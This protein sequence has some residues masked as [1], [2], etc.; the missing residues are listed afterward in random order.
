MATTP[1]ANP[2]V[3]VPPDQE[4]LFEFKAG[5]MVANG[6]R[7]VP[8]PRK[9]LVRLVKAEDTLL[10]FQWWDRTTFLVEDD[11][12][13]FPEEATFEKVGQ[14]SGRVY[15]L[16]FKYDERKSF[17]W[18]QELDKDQDAGVCN[19]VTHH[20]NH[21]LDTDGEDEP[22]DSP[23]PLSE[24]SEGIA[25]ELLEATAMSRDLTGGNLS[26]PEGIPAGSSTGV[27]QLADLQ[28]ILSG[29]GQP[30]EV[31][32]SM[33]RDTGPGF[34]E[35]LRPDV[36]R[37]LLESLQLEERL[38]PYLPEGVRS[39]QA[40]AELMQSPQ[41]HQQLDAFTQVI[42]SGQIDLS[43]FGMDTSGYNFT[44]ASF[45]EAI[46]DQAA[47]GLN[48]QENEDRSNQDVMEEGR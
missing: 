43:Q 13:V 11:Q 36:V 1:A 7:V 10:H 46:E 12:I 3:P 37:P 23:Q 44:V 32:Y 19:I 6:T 16:K 24:N 34:S 39:K 25:N 20:L 4:V 21:P 5:K 14:S 2:K 35:L 38:A 27:V 15:L 28:R 18:M 45:L 41:F 26:L 8:D 29:I 33:A 42:R 22:E 31:D 9:G 30:P 17:F 48:E 40:I 47:S